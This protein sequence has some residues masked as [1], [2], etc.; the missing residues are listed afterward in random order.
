VIQVVKE[1]YLT[2][3]RDV[4]GDGINGLNVSVSDMFPVYTAGI[5]MLAMQTQSQQLLYINIYF[6]FLS[7]IKSL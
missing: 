5:C 7:F 3:K 6:P 1:K 4:V 2:L